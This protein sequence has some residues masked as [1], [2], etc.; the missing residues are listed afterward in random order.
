MFLTSHLFSWKFKETRIV[1]TWLK[2]PKCL[3]SVLE[4][5]LQNQDLS[6]CLMYYTPWSV[7]RIFW[8]TYS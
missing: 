8:L 6:L 4:P 7:L 2:F 1:E 5:N 3:N